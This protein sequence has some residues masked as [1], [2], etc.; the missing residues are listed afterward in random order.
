MT[1]KRHREIKQGK[2]LAAKRGED[3]IGLQPEVKHNV[4]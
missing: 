3:D 2:K 4:R 1:G